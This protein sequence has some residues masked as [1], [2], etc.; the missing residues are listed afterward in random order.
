MAQRAVGHWQLMPKYGPNALALAAVSHDTG[1]NAR[2]HRAQHD[3]QRGNEWKSDTPSSPLPG[4]KE[5][6]SQAREQAGGCVACLLTCGSS[7]DVVINPLTP[8]SAPEQATSWLRVRCHTAQHLK[9]MQ[10][11]L[12]N[13]VRLSVSALRGSASPMTCSDG[14]CSSDANTSSI[15]SA[16]RDREPFIVITNRQCLGIMPLSARPNKEAAP[17]VSKKQQNAAAARHANNN[18]I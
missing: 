9:S 16:Q 2:P 4:P 13:S 10:A 11:N 14:I 17:M 5:T 15:S 1:Q 7:V 3:L 6:H 8:S 18:S 12:Y